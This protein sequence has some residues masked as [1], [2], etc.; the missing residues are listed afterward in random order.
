MKLILIYGEKDAGKTTTCIRLL[1]SL[2]AL[3]GVVKFYDTFDWENDFRAII[4]FQHRRVGIY[5]PGDERGH[6]RDALSFGTDNNCDI[7]VAT[8]RK[9]IAYNAPLRETDVANS[10][11][12]I[13][14][15]KGDSEEWMDAA[16]NGAVI[17]ILD[18]IHKS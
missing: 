10:V 5:S 11:E 7:L 14:L 18:K 9:G 1:R 3:G 2:I 4:E 12:W 6:L 8:V 17:E 15:D 16:E 13:E